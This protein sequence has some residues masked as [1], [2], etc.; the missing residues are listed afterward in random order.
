MSKAQDGKCKICGGTELKNL[1]IDHDH[2]TG[3]I[4]GLLCMRCNMG[5]GVYEAR[6]DD[7][8]KYLQES[9]SE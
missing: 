5:L 3:K 4:R 8:E 1:H 6:K 9:T 7:F 2:A